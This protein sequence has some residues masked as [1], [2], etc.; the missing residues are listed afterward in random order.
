MSAIFGSFVMGSSLAIHKNPAMLIGIGLVA[1]VSGWLSVPFMPDAVRADYYGAWI[2]SAT[3]IIVGA[4][5]LALVSS[6]LIKRL[7]KSVPAR[8]GAGVL[9]GLVASSIFIL[10]TEYGVDKGICAVLGYA[11]PLPDFLGVGGMYWMGIQAFL[12]PLGYMAGE[13]CKEYFSTHA[14]LTPSLSYAH[15]AAITVLFAGSGAVAFAVGA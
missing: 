11:R 8:I 7:E 2:A 13:K 15:L 12:L 9:S 10:V 1:A 4:V 5:S 3:A 6:F 14:R